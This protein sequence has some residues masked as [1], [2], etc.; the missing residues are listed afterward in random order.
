[1]WSANRKF[2]NCHICGRFRKSKSASPQLCGFAIC[3][4]YLQ[5]ARLWPIYVNRRIARIFSY[6]RNT[7]NCLESI[8]EFL[9]RHTVIFSL[10][11]IPLFISFSSFKILTVYSCDHKFAS[12]LFTVVCTI[13]YTATQFMVHL[14]TRLTNYEWMQHIRFGFGVCKTYFV[15]VK[16]SICTYCVKYCTTYRVLMLAYKFREAIIR[17]IVGFDLTDCPVVRALHAVVVLGSLA[18]KTERCA[19]SPAPSYNCLNASRRD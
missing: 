11:R 9:V 8:I 2:A 14:H 16:V 4:T 7:I 1:M 3:E 10:S 13:R 5:T 18:R 15:Y 19:P 12:K 17:S 6:Q